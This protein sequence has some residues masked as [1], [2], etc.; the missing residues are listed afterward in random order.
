MLIK[1]YR[2]YISFATARCQSKKVIC[3]NGNGGDNLISQCQLCAFRNVILLENYEGLKLSIVE[4]TDRVIT[5]MQSVLV[6][7]GPFL[8]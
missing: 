2:S 1:Y 5:V 7:T 8:F 6:A 4:V 3:H